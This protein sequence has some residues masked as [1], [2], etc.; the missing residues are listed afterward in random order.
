MSIPREIP[1]G[2]AA[3]FRWATTDGAQGTGILAELLAAG[4]MTVGRHSW[5]GIWL[6]R[7][8]E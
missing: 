7:R 2:S 1:I 8:D 4:W 6:M 5:Y 3:L